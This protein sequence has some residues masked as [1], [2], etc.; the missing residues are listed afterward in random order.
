[1]G[2]LDG[3]VA[4]V[5][6]G[7]SGIGRETARMLADEGAQVVVSGRRQKPLD[8][9]VAAIVR[10][11]GKAVARA[12]DME[13]TT[14]PVA[15]AEWTIETFGRV[16]ILINNAG[17]SSTVR[18]I[19]W[20]RKVDWDSVLA[21]NLT[22]V[23]LITQAVLPG[24]IER[25]GGTIVTVSSVAGIRPGLMG[26][27][28]YSAAKAA[29]RNLMG[30]IHSEHRDKG[31]RATTILPAEVDTPILE[32]RPLPPGAKA[33]ATMMQPEDVAHAI[34][35]CVTLPPRTVIE[36]IVMV[37]TVQRDMSEDIRVAGAIGGPGT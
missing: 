17:H 31:I 11:G 10:A 20:V 36:E 23:Y 27:V 37:P 8:E 16:D 15:L 26:G 1:M 5:T 33:R 22:G 25:G 35:L 9:T 18:A 6:G 21:A 2:V 30:H 13:S 12:A 14:D 24:M 29:V 4:I 32:R 3:Q 28:P 34:M 19:L 7:G